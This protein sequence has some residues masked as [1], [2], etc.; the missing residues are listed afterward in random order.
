MITPNEGERTPDN[1]EK[2]TMDAVAEVATWLWAT[3]MITALV[4]IAIGLTFW[5]LARS[6]PG[7]QP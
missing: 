5:L 2:E 6:G 1:S 7:K 3:W 4:A